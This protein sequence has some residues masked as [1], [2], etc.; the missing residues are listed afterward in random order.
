VHWCRCPRLSTGSARPKGYPTGLAC[1]SPTAP[2]PKREPGRMVTTIVQLHPRVRHA[3]V[4]TSGVMFT[5]SRHPIP[6]P[7]VDSRVPS[8]WGSDNPKVHSQ[9]SKL[10]EVTNVTLERVIL[11][12]PTVQSRVKTGDYTGFNSSGLFLISSEV[13]VVRRVIRFLPHEVTESHTSQDPAERLSW[14]AWRTCYPNPLYPF[15]ENCLFLIAT[16]NHQSHS[17]TGHK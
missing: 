12:G 8:S 4:V 1:T 2:S 10:N 6:K 16:S 14:L 5:Y 13:V 17:G 7:E 15:P 11:A 9:K 3:I